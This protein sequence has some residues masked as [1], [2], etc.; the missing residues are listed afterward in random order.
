MILKY[1]LRY[2]LCAFAIA[3]VLV[4]LFGMLPAVA[5]L[6]PCQTA[7]VH[8]ISTHHHP[9]QSQSGCC[10]AMHCCPMLPAL[11]AP[12][13]PSEARL[14]P[15]VYLKAEQPLLLVTSI[16]PPPRSPAS[17]SSEYATPRNRSSK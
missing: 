8:D 6:P 9:V 3:T 2:V 17:R 4:S 10:D 5:A 12:E 14:S 1:S 16:D 13:L 7:H 11:P 15:H